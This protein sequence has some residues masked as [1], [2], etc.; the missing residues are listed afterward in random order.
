MNSSSQAKEVVP[1]IMTLNFMLVILL[2]VAPASESAITCG[3]VISSIRP[4]I[5]YLQGTGGKPP[6][7]CCAGCQSLA[8][9]TATTP[10]RQ[11]ACTCLKNASQKININAQLA[12]GLPQNCGISLSF[13][14]STSVDCTKVK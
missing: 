12:Q 6:Q 9:A 10:D 8:S 1:S 4:C 14:I 5:S 7:S 2:L 11:A 13:P 3:T